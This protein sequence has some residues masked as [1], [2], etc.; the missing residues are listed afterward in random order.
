MER[1]AMS[2]REVERGVVWRRVVAGELRVREAAPVLGVC[3]RHARR[4]VAR[5]R[6]CGV[7]GLVHAARGRPSNRTVPP[8]YRAQ[9]L[10][11]VRQHYGGPAA[12]GPGQR[13]GP[14]LAAEHLWTDHGLRVPVTTLRRWMRAAPRL[15]KPQPVPVRLAPT[16]ARP[17]A[18][19]PWRQQHVA[20]MDRAMRRRGLPSVQPPIE[21]L[22][23]SHP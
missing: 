6:A 23:P 22:T 16:V 2:D 13:F 15:P 7:K 3:Y 10:E 14:T 1:T 5:F 12:R 20:W 17:A 19:H 18:H 8:V 4:R 11:L 9:V 21:I